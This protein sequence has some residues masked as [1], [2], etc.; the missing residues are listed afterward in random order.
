[1][2]EDGVGAAIWHRPGLAPDDEQIGGL[3]EAAVAPG[4]R[5]DVYALLEQMQRHHPDAPTWYLPFI[6]IDP[7]AQGNGHGSRLLV[8]GLERCDRD[9]LPAYLEASS[10]RNR[11]STS[12]M[13]SR[14][15]TRS[16][17]RTRHRSGRC[18]D[19]RGPDDELRDVRIAPVAG[20]GI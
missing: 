16:S 1:M 11:A 6:G 2:L 18:S 10:R 8:R 15:W 14:S 13:A 5:P 19:R 9:G 12:V 17:W 20:G 4:R 7:P 3:L